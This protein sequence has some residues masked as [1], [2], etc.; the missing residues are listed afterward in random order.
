MSDYE[1]VIG[2]EVHA[3]LSTRSKIF[4]S[5]TTAFGGDPNTHGCPV[6]LGMPGSLPVLNRQ[7]V[8]FAIKAALA[9]DC[10]VAS[11]S[12]FAR[13]NYFYP[14]LPKGYQISQYDK[15]LAEHGFIE[16]EDAGVQ[17]KI[18]LTR[19]HLEEDAGKL[20][21]DL[22]GHDSHFDV[23]RCGTP[24]IE[25][26]SEPEMHTPREAYLYLTKLKQILE[27]LEICDCNM[28]E[29]S[30]RC[31]ANVS[32]RPVGEQK[33]GTK[34]ELKNMNSFHGVEKALAYEIKR[35]KQVLEDGGKIIQQTLLWDASRNIAEPMR[36]KED[37]HDY[38]Y[39]PDPDLV[40][41]QV[42]EAW[43]KE[44]SEIMPE[45][46]DARRERFL[47]QYL[48]PAYDADVLTASRS[49]ADY[50]EAAEKEA[51]DPKRVSN[52]VQTEVLRLCKE[53]KCEIHQLRATPQRL[54]AILVQVKEGKING[55]AAK[56][57]LAA[58]E[59]TGKDPEE[60]IQEKGLA[61]I[62][63]EDEIEGIVDSVISAHPD[64]AAAYKAGKDKLLGF[65]MG[66]IMK[67][68]KGKANP[69]VATKLLKQK[70][71]E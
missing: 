66:Q 23:N 59:E 46:A 29:G 13:K 53:K 70:L 50:F 69:G 31:D 9:T 24:L 25:I 67:A 21:H 45:L 12:V 62:S 2:L 30:L 26:V 14:D 33:L 10:T 65:F 28:E 37:A 68:A 39:F 8:E 7:V 20:I 40:P 5:C 36:T 16:I 43:K 15:P 38:R 35:Q 61:Q 6:C 55:N 49:V 47:K 27:Y 41:V 3:Q 34:T 71:S 44:I 57:V 17:K 58:V 52:W 63:G 51:Q 22:S 64:E 4:C 48:L 56:E 1:A 18:G 19:I 32:I 11:E 54:A 60:I 42:T